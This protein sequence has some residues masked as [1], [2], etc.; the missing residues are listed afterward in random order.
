MD[1]DLFGSLAMELGNL[2]GNFGIVD[3]GLDKHE[4]CYIARLHL[5]TV[6]S[7]TLIIRRRNLV[8]WRMIS[9]NGDGLW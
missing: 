2:K 8:G 6:G 4:G 1:M 9:V 3:L 5:S 7:N